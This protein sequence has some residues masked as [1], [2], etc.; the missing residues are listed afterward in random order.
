MTAQAVHDAWDHLL[1]GDPSALDAQALQLMRAAA[2]ILEATNAL[3]DVA[4]GQ[5]SEA[6]DALQHAADDVQDALTRAER[7]YR[8]TGAALR[9]FA[10]EVAPIQRSARVH[11]QDLIDAQS[12]QQHADA[13]LVDAND[14]LRTTTYG[15]GSD[16]DIERLQHESRLANAHVE[17]AYGDVS[18]ALAALR[19]DDRAREDAADR[20]IRAIEDVISDGA[21]SLLDRIRQVWDG[22][23]ELFSA[24]AQWAK[25]VLA[26]V[27]QR[28]TSALMSLVSIIVFA[29]ALVLAVVLLVQI[30]GALA[31]LL[32]PLGALF[33]GLVFAAAGL[34]LVA[35]AAVLVSFVMQELT[36]EPNRHD[37]SESPSLGRH[38]TPDGD[39]AHDYGDLI[40]QVADKDASG[41]K[42]NAMDIKVVAITD[43]DGNVVAWRVQ[44]PSTQFWSPFNKAGMNDLATDAMLSFF[45]GMQTQY[46]KAV[47][48]AMKRAGVD[49]SDAPIMFTGW[50]LGGMEAVKLA[51]NPQYADRVGAV[52][53]AGSAIDKYGDRIGPNVNVTQINNV[54][55]PVHH[56]EFVGLGPADGIPRPNWRTWWIEDTRIH[57]GAMYAEGADTVVPKPLPADEKFFADAGAGTHEVTYTE[58]Y[59][60]Q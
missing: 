44:C 58:R 42:A 46:E 22:A 14:R 16:A 13:A 26:E 4:H 7:R 9:T 24:V 11:I 29:T 21:D 48:D 1:Q 33:L 51:T 31:L 41:T 27:V 53:T 57:D 18:A 40:R 43:A 19:A 12:R 23:V 38:D 49:R 54:L 3:T 10:V 25:T 5:R 39:A 20:A 34:A 8:G 36:G 17:N 32:G 15:G 59:S 50:S 2:A 60:R 45:P 52:V 55:D 47:L 28:L 6:T 35:I 37:E 56:L 30:I